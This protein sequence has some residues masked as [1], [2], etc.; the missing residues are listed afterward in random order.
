MNRSSKWRVRRSAVMWVLATMSVA[1]AGAAALPSLRDL[2]IT[3]VPAANA[4]NDVFAVL[5]SGDGGWAQLDKEVSAELAS[6]GIPVAG[7]D[8]LHYFWHERTPEQTATDVGRIIEHYSTQWHRPRVLLIGY[9][10]GADVMPAVFDRLAPV[11]RARVA[12]LSLLGLAK[13]ASYEVGASEWI[14]ALASKGPLV[15]SDLEKIGGLPILCVEGEGEEKS[16]CPALPR[17]GVQVRQI[18]YQHHFSYLKSQIADAVLS[19]ARVTPAGAI[20]N[21]P[22]IADAAT[23]TG[24]KGSG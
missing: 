21:R 14:P 11:S 24:Q 13:R 20:D 5:I 8:S 12:S 4:G 10:F 6:R 7:L 19:V 9:S 15:L 22:K 17:L 23:R 3:E 18:G 2:P 16:I 1:S